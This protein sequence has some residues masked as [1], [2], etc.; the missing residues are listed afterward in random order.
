MRDR[1]P[2][3]H[4]PDFHADWRPHYE[5]RTVTAAEAIA[6]IKS[7]DRVAIAR[8]REPQALGLAL[9]ARKDELR[10]VRVSVP[11]PGRDFGWYDEGWQDSFEVEVGINMATSREA[12]NAHRISLRFNNDLADSHPVYGSNSTLGTD[13]LLIEISPP[14]EQGFCSFGA[15]VWEKRRAIAT[16]KLVLAEVNPRMIRTY[17]E[18]WCHVTEIDCFVQNEAPTGWGVLSSPREAPPLAKRFA[19]LVS[20]LVEDGDTVQIGL[21]TIS[22]WIPR[23]GAFDNKVD[24]GLHTEITPRG[25]THLIKAGVINGKRKTIN[26]GKCTATAGGGSSEDVQFIHM[27]PTFE[28]LSVYNVINPLVIAQH[29]NMVAVNQAMAVDLTGQITAEGLGGYQ[30]SGPGGQPIFAIGSQMSRNGRYIVL[31]PSTARNGAV[32]RVMARLPEGTPVTVSRNFADIV[33]TEY[34]IAY[35]RWKN[36]RERADALIGIAHPDFRAE[37][38]RE[39]RRMFWPE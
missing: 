36:W 32:S 15:S 35:L 34:G 19:E 21:G 8:G 26:V 30:H 18:N 33:V 13:A 7:G 39:A 4:Q 29:D 10:G 20:G 24:L 9:A 38:R 28:L 12:L 14:D 31:L 2:T 25:M 3:L 11:Q 16:A 17:G 5:R 22:E 23:L 1:L 6:H 27:N 37:L